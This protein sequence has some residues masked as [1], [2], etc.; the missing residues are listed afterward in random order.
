MKLTTLILP[1]LG[2]SG[3]EHWQTIWEKSHPSFVRVRQRDWDHPDCKE[4]IA[5]LEENVARAGSNTVI[6]AHS[7]G[8]L[9]VAHW[10]IRSKIGIKGALLVAPVNPDGPNI[11]TEV[12]GFSP[13]PRQRLTFPSIV[14]AST[15]DPYGEIEFAESIAKSW[16]GRFVSIGAVGHINAESGLGSWGEGLALYKQLTE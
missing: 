8:C 7:L 16:G 6:I 15:N 11:P 2:N 13:L 14:V 4:W 3:S 5:I 9:L 12:T 1:G 10:A